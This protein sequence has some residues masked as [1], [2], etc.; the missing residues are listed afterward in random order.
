MRLGWNA[1][2]GLVFIAFLTLLLILPYT[3]QY[4]TQSEIHSEP[5][6]TSLIGNLT[7]HDTIWINGNEMFIEQA[8]LEGWPGNGTRES[9]Y[10]ISGYY[11]NTWDKPLTIYHS[12][13]HW[14]FTN[15]IID[16]E[17]EH[18]GTWIQNC[19]N[20]AIVNNEFC[21]RRFAIAVA[22]GSGINISGNYI[23]DCWEN[24]IEF[25]A[26]MTSAFVQNNTIENIGVAG[27]YSGLSHDSIVAN[28]TLT[29]C[30]NYGFALFGIT[31]NCTLTG[32]TISKCGTETIEGVGMR[33]MSFETSEI[34]HNRITDCTS[35]GILID[36]GN[37]A[38]IA[39]NTIT[40]SSG[41]AVTLLLDSSWILVKSNTFINN[42]IN[43]Q[44]SDN[45][46][47]NEFTHNYYSDWTT[48]DYNADGYVD[49]P[50]HIDGTSNNT[51]IYPQADT[52]LVPSES[53]NFSTEFIVVLG[54]IV[55][56][57]IVIAMRMR[58]RDT[59]N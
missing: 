33:I 46:T 7:P 4:G 58:L 43:C 48:P 21:N 17:D 10:L 23:H 1:N 2:Q 47:L 14:V 49:V 18:G 15:N 37:N 26:G 19:T 6:K 42:G 44:V 16:G 29:N 50:Y 40:N 5:Q 57:V 13:L 11:F 9:P 20:G 27:F 36:R 8:E 34:S 25:M 30:G 51:D 55:G 22:A 28:N 52:E 38:S 32:N 45:G 24:G 53:L 56:F 41:Y 59:T 35:H 39:W 31:S 54:L 12:T 3:V